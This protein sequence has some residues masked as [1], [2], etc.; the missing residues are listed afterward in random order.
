[1]AF[2]APDTIPLALITDEIMSPLTRSD[3]VPTLAAAALVR[4][5]TL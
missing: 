2:F 4:V 1:L 5:E 3:G